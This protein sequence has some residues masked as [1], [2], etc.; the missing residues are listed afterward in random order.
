[1]K[2]GQQ[3]LGLHS[4]VY[5]KYEP[6]GFKIKKKVLLYGRNV[7]HRAQCRAKVFTNL[8]NKIKSEEF[9]FKEIGSKEIK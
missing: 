1:M 5:L 4:T 7:P 2:S 8:V 9:Y 6:F 3:K